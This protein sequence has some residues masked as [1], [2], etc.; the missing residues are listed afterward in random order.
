MPK[1]YS[2]FSVLLNESIDALNIKKD[3]IYVDC[4]LGGG[5][6]SSKILGKKSFSFPP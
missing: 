5:G 6:H 2:H 3:G 4:T 1:E